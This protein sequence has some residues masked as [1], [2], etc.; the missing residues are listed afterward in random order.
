[1]LFR[2]SKVKD[3]VSDLEGATHSMSQTDIFG[4]WARPRKSEIIPPFTVTSSLA[5]IPAKT[6]P[7]RQ[8]S[9][10]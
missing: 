9:S 7:Q 4:L 1:M 10:G 5:A 3:D 8:F 6:S 2:S